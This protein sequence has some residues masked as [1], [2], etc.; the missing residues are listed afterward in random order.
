MGR[1]SYVCGE[2]SEHFT[3]RSSGRRHNNN[4]HAGR[5]D[6]VPLIEYIIA[7]SQGRYVPIRPSWSKRKPNQQPWQKLNT[8]GER[9]LSTVT[10]STQGIVK[11]QHDDLA[12]QSKDGATYSG[13]NKTSTSSRQ[14][15][16]ISD[17]PVA[18]NRSYDYVTLQ[19]LFKCNVLFPDFLPINIMWDLLELEGLLFK[20]VHYQP[21]DPP[22]ILQNAINQCSRGDNRFLGVKL[23]Q[24]RQMNSELIGREKH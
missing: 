8:K 14:Q 21:F 19:S 6:I 20:L 13:H 11:P 15:A 24:L 1:L 22:L 7:R 3:R 4:L 16:P 12:H 17:Y 5:A 18:R 2:C 9:L 23:K 10:D